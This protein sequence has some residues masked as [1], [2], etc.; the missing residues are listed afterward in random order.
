MECTVKTF[1]GQRSPSDQE[2]CFEEIESL[3]GTDEPYDGL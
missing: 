2:H 1:I 3:Q